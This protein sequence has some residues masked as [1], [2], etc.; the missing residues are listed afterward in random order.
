MPPGAP[1]CLA[2]SILAAP[3]ALSGQVAKADMTRLRERAPRST[4]ATFDS[5]RP[6]R[7]SEL[8]ERHAR[9]REGFRLAGLPEH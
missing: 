4:V 9:P 7:H 5:T 8:V 2:V 6:S 1:L 3:Q